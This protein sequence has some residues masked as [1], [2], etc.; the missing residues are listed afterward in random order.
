MTE[1]KK[2]EV[3]NSII[4][5]QYETMIVEEEKKMQIEQMLLYLGQNGISFTLGYREFGD[6]RAR[7]AFRENV[8]YQIPLPGNSTEITYRTAQI[9]VHSVSNSHIDFELLTACEQI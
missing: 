5:T 1:R 9:R 6:G 2:V 7:E 3:G 4:S 8:T